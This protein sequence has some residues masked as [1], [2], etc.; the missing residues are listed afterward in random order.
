MQFMYLHRLVH[1]YLSPVTVIKIVFLFCIPLELRKN[2]IF[3]FWM[4]CWLCFFWL[5]KP[6]PAQAAVPK[7][8]FYPSYLWVL[9][10]GL[11]LQVTLSPICAID[12]ASALQVLTSRL[13]DVNIVTLLEL[14]LRDY[15][16][17]DCTLQSLTKTDAPF[18]A[19]SLNTN[20]SDE[21]IKYSSMIDSN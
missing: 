11:C 20:S 1:T 5:R 15:W 7:T 21:G 9:L 14:Y 18:S 10:P 4:R 19:L 16:L 3:Y 2:N 6:F 17:R 12:C 8:F 13:G